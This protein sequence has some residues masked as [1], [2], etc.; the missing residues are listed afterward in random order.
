M[1][2]QFRPSYC[3]LAATLALGVGSGPSSGSE[4]AVDCGCCCEASAAGWFTADY[5]HWW[6]QGDRVPAL[7]TSSPSGTA[8]AD[9]GQLELPTTAVLFGDDRIND[10]G[11]PGVRLGLGRW[12]DECGQW[13]IGGEFFW[14]GEDDDGFRAFSDGD[15]ALARPFFN[16][17]P[18]VNGQDAQLIAFDDSVNGDVLDGGVSVE[19][20]SDIYS[21]NIDLHQLAVNNV[22]GGYGW[23]IEALAGYRF[24]R[25]DENLRISEDLLVTGGGGGVVVGTTFDIFDE[26]GASNEFHGFEVGSKTRCYHGLWTIDMLA[27][28]GIGNNHQR[29][30]ID[31]VTVVTVP[32]FA[33]L[34]SSGGLLAQDSNIGAF[35]HDSFALLPE[36]QI[37]LARQLND[38]WE[39]RVGYTLLFLTDVVRPG[40]H[41]DSSADGRFLDP[42]SPPFTPTN[43]AFTLDE[44][45]IW[46]QGVNFGLACQF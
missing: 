29:V 43:P 27:K 42:L 3:I 23:R 30:R 20:A 44:T 46:L 38:Y 15:P 26:F 21:V 37:N 13:A 12:I 34:A 5:L 6:L 31:G 36:L 2:P 41:I 33:P 45:S 11:R 1:V 28:L 8:Q 4:P 24:F 25:L 9:A 10:R 22:S 32:N 40:G 18:N 39:F 35:E 16:T 19:T 14:V 7:V 17:D